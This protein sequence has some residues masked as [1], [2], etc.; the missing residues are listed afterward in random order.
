MAWRKLP[1]LTQDASGGEETFQDC[2]TRDE[3]EMTTVT[4]S[5]WSPDMHIVE[6]I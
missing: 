3:I 1:D 4:K 6:V 2:S 5:A